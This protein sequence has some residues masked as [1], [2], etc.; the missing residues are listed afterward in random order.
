MLEEYP[1]RSVMVR[2]VFSIGS[3]A[4][5][6][7]VVPLLPVSTGVPVKVGGFAAVVCDGPPAFEKYKNVAAAGY[8]L[9]AIGNGKPAGALPVE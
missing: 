2:C 9:P 8:G 5:P 3:N 1:Y 6:A 7:I 4:P